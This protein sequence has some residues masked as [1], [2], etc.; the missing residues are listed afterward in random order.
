MVEGEGGER[1]RAAY[2]EIGLAVVHARAEAMPENAIIPG[3]LEPA[4]A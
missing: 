1:T 3:W 4:L 2:P